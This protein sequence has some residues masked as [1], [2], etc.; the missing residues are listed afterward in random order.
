MPLRAN[1]FV[2]PIKQEEART[3]ME[4]LS[5]AGKWQL[6]QDG[7]PPIPGALPGSTYLD[8]IA[9]GMADPFWGENETQANEL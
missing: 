9:N 5:L 7:K 1:I 2:L 4:K 3:Q 8:Y 6:S